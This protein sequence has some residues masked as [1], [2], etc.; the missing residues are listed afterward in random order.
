MYNMYNNNNNN[1]YMYKYVYIHIY[2]YIYIYVCIY[3]YI[4]I[5]IYISHVLYHNKVHF[6][7]II[8]NFSPRVLSHKTYAR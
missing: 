1:L 3:I 7:G 2:I 6:D 5:Y 4:Y 8:V